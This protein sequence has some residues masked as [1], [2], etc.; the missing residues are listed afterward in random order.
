MHNL[1]KT[2]AN[3]FHHAGSGKNVNLLT[4]VRNSTAAFLFRSGFAFSPL[5]IFISVNSICNLKCKMCDIGQKN[6]ESPFYKNLATE[7][8][9]NFLDFN[10]LKKLLH[11]VSHYKPLPRI[12][13]TTTEPFLYA[14]LF[15]LAKLTHSYGMEFQVTTNGSLLKKYLDHLFISGITELCISIDAKGSLHDEIRG[16]KG[17]Y[18]SIIEAL[19]IIERIK[20][21]NKWNFPKIMIAATIS[22]YNF[23]SIQNLV[24]D[25]D[26]RLYDRMIISHMNFVTDHMANAHNKQY[27]QIGKADITGLPGD[28]DNYDV[29]PEI[30][31][32]Q[33]VAIKKNTAKV[34]F[35]P[36]YNLKELRRFYHDPSLF[37]WDS[38]CFIPWFVMEVLSNGD[39][40]PM[41]RC[42]NIVMGNIY[43]DSIN[44]IWN[45]DKYRSLRRQLITHRRFPVCSRCRGIL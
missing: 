31:H 15:N 8:S 26:E 2:I 18:D 11:E 21:K 7:D 32:K 4:L 9:R 42:L 16:K 34:S 44:D 39:V 33:I 13:V 30:L 22:N 10:R 37:V 5:T 43:G 29:D 14:D 40:I 20:R 24:E 1:I 35:A 28:T 36:D 3:A 41:T 12:S 27:A 25:I 38:R 23:H 6:I 17:L 45:N 19:E